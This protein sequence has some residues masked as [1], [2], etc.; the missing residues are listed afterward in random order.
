MIIGYPTNLSRAMINP[1][2]LNVEHFLCVWETKY[3]ND[4]SNYKFQYCDSEISTCAY[5]ELR[6]AMS[7]WRE[8]EEILTQTIEKYKY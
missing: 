2:Q 7:T 6:N 3:L 8:S 5:L 1:M 4:K